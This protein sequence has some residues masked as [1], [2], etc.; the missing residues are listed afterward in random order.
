MIT[1]ILLALL[2]LAAFLRAYSFVFHRP[3]NFPP[4]LF[5]IYIRVKSISNHR[6]A[7]IIQ[8]EIIGMRTKEVIELLSNHELYQD[9]LR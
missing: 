9:T 8:S 5:R 6:S 7:M 2:S 4:G 3:K 1:A